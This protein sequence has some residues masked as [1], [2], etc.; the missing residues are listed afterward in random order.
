[1][2]NIVTNQ[3]WD[4][5]G[6]KHVITNRLTSEL[7]VADNGQARLVILLPESA[8]RVLR[9]AGRELAKYL[10]MMSGAAFR[11]VEEKSNAVP[12]TGP[13]IRLECAETDDPTD[14]FSLK[15]TGHQ[16]RV[17][18]QSRRGVL[19]GVYALLE[20]LGCC[21]VEPGIERVPQHK[22]LVIPCLDVE[23]AGAFPLRNIFRNYVVPTTKGDFTF[24]HP[25]LAL[26]QIDWMAK[27]RLN[28]YEFYIDYYRYDLWEKYKHQV[29]DALLDRG[30]IL[31]VTHHSIHYFCPPDENHDFGEFGPASYQRNHPDWY[32]PSYECGSRG[33]WQTRV[34]LPA[35]QDIIIKRYLDYCGRNPELKIVGLWPDD[36]PMNAPS[37]TMNPADGYLKSFWNHVSAAL[38]HE[39][40][41]NRLGIIAYFELIKPPLRVKPHPNQH[42]WFC[43]IERDLRYPVDHARNRHFLSHLK[44]WVE[45]MSPGQVGIFEYYGWQ[46]S[47]LP[48]RRMMANDLLLYQDLKAGGIYGWSG[49]GYNALGQDYR[50][51]LDL[52]LL[53]HFLWNPKASPD[54]LKE[55]WAAEVFGRAGG[56]VLDFYDHLEQAFLRKTKLGFPLSNC[57]WLD[58]ETLHGAQAILGAARKRANSDSA[59]RRIDLLEKQAACQC[60]DRTLQRDPP[61]PFWPG[62]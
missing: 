27:R 48:H 40:P 38:E 6:D 60:T 8:D 59:K 43:P 31:E 15:T 56:R 52:L 26:P 51:A 30:F 41:G 55:S 35:V 36:V 2:V 42:C 53:T 4:A 44:G 22:T 54:A 17:R 47:F 29:L 1:M 10:S 39:R 49:F 28:H 32:I 50:W 5:R 62:V 33:R 24:L 3:K 46:N 61:T 19:Y 16:I 34:E 9:F 12:R 21:F 13:A 14:G 45:R 23:E 18:G 20:R 7:A 37:K 25:K 11:I 57:E 58:L